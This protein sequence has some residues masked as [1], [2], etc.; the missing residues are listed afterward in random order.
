M[1]LAQQ[2]QRCL[3][4]YD[5]NNTIMTR[6]TIAIATMAK[7]PAHQWQQCHHD[8]GNNASFTTRNEDNNASLTM[9]EMP[10]HQRRQ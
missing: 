9:V 3:R 2:R 10:A 1:T 6:A 8:K 7:T 5:G 4:I